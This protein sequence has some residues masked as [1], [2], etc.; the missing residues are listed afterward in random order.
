MQTVLAVIPNGVYNIALDRNSFLSVQ[1]GTSGM[2]AYLIP[3]GGAPQ[4]QQWRVENDFNAGTVL[5]RHAATN[6][7]L[8]P[9][10]PAEKQA[11]DVLLLTPTRFAWTDVQSPSGTYYIKRAD[12][13][14]DQHPLVWARSPSTGGGRTPVETMWWKPY[15]PTQEW[16]FHRL[17]A[18]QDEMEQ[19]ETRMQC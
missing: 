3:L 10:D 16:T 7:Y 9:S 1:M 13:V 18:F 5:I 17:G 6:L 14:H 4:L 19:E 2:P 11:R 12:S 15:D 8:A